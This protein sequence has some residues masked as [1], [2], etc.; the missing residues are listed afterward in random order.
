MIILYHF[1]GFLSSIYFFKLS[2]F[3]LVHLKVNCMTLNELLSEEVKLP[4]EL[5]L[6]EEEILDEAKHVRPDDYNRE[7]VP[8]KNGEKGH[9][10]PKQREVMGL[11]PS[12][13]RVVHHKNGNKHDNRKSNLQVVSRAEHCKIDPNA[14]QYT[15]C[16]V[17]GCK[18]PHYSHH[19]CKMHYMRA[20]RKGKFGKYDKDKNYSKKD[21]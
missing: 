13:P 2:S 14:L 8:G 17:P 7:W 19:L 3:L 11:S 21:R 16:K 4:E 10:L 18:R 5:L 20:F 1:L 12:D 9:W 6:S 15:D